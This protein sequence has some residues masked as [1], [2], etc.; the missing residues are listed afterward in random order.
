[1]N[2]IQG[3]NSFTATVCPE[4]T[5]VIYS[6]YPTSITAGTLDTLTILGANLGS[7]IDPTTHVYFPNADDG[8]QT[9]VRTN[10]TDRVLWAEQTIKLRV[11]SDAKQPGTSTYGM[12]GSGIFKLVLADSVILSAPDTLEVR[13]AN[14]NIV[15]LDTAGAEN[16]YRT[17]LYSQ[18][19]NGGMDFYLSEQI[20]DLPG[21]AMLIDEAMLQWRCAT[22]V[23]FKIV[24][25]TSTNGPANEGVN[26]IYGLPSSSFPN[27]VAAET[28]VYTREESCP[29]SSG[30]IAMHIKDIDLG[31]NLSYQWT[32]STT[33]DI[34]PPD[35]TWGDLFSVVLHELGHAHLLGHSLPKGE[36][37][38]WRIS[39]GDTIRTLKTN[40]IEGGQWVVMLSGQ[41]QGAECLNEMIAFFPQDCSP[42]NSIME[43]GSDASELLAFPNPSDDRVVIDGPFDSSLQYPYSISDHTGNTVFRAIWPPQTE[44]AISLKQIGLAAGFYLISIQGPTHLLHCKMLYVP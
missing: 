20:A 36:T 37:M 14:T 10:T 5:P 2:P 24:G 40:D 3:T 1:M 8:G 7:V 34:V 43:I 11:P 44:R 19:G 30:S 12:A 38:Y 39:G 28:S 42:S 25:T 29:T 21:Y 23:N 41:E 17:E 32:V 31:I 16:T 27:N 26:V 15:A 13:F 4:S 18:N 6:F 35:T 9:L 22:G 33:P